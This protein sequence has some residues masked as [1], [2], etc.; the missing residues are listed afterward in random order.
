MMSKKIFNDASAPP[1]NPVAGLEFYVSPAGSDANQGSESEPFASV[2]RAR[3]AVRDVN[4]TMTG[5]IVVYLREGT[6]TPDCPLVFGHDDSGANGFRVIYRSCPGE[7]VVISGGREV[8][9][10][11]E[12]EGGVWKTHVEVA[13]IRQLYVNGE[14]AGRA[15]IAAPAGLEPWG[16]HGYRTRNDSMMDLPNPSDI[17][18]CYGVMWT[19]R[20]CRVASITRNGEYAEICMQQPYFTAAHTIEGVQVQYPDTLANCRAFLRE[21]GQ[22]YFD[23]HEQTLYYLPAPGRTPADMEVV[24]PVLE[25]LIE[26]RGTL[27]EPVRD[28]AFEGITLAHA[29][30]LEPSRCG[31]FV[32]LQANFTYGP[33]TRLFL[34][35]GGSSP[36][37]LGALHCEMTKSPANIVCHAARG[38]R[39][40]GCVFTRLGGAGIDV[41]YGS[42]D[43]VISHCEF[44]DISGTAVQVGDVQRHDH[45][46]DDPRAVVQDNRVVESRIHN[47]AREYKGGVG[48][49]VGYTD[50]TVLAHNE[51]Y[52]L[53]YSGISVGWGWGE[54][55]AGGGG[56]AHPA[57][58]D[59]PTPSRDNRIECNHIHHVM[60]EL[61]DGG[62]IYT[63]GEMPG[64]VIRGNHI[65]DNT[66][67]PGGIYLDEGSGH[68]EVTEN[69]VYR[70]PHAI[71]YN[72]KAQNRV[73]T[74]V[75]EGNF[76]DVAPAAENFPTQL[77][78][79]AGPQ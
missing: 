26:L 36:G 4:R 52:D 65:H 59:T 5:N 58:F 19:H 12:A 2:K 79:G 35:E 78:T 16:L 42:R 21:P 68:I 69:A 56:Y 11:E 27:D 72:N 28:I 53:P 71:F 64:T 74:C 6:Y 30:W 17:E 13:D 44:T 73:D 24:V 77:A 31:G 45:H 50:G 57:L 33:E 7:N 37:C 39:F 54:T 15:A 22:W 8:S 51:I 48:V 63:L 76:F 32:D 75:E 47:V 3:D 38:V 34:R 10:W 41:E 66:N 43:C 9:G 49:F 40:E 62:A 18:F 29:T 61:D 25:T 14:R 20:R 60:L 1:S 46:P 67:M 23:R 55:D 70:T